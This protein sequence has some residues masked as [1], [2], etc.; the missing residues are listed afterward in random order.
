MSSNFQTIKDIRDFFKKELNDLYPEK[1]ISGIT[2]LILK[3]QFGIDRLH[4]FSDPAR[5][6]PA[7]M[8]A[9]IT[10]IC[11]EL[12][13]GRPIQYIIG[14]TLFFDCIIRVNYNTLIPRPETEEL[15]DLIIRENKEFNGKIIDFGTG[16]GCIAIA[17][18]KNLP[19]SKITG[20]DI[21][22]PALDLARSNALKNN[23]YIEFCKGDILH[24]DFRLCPETDI[25]VSNPPYVLESEKQFME[26]NIIDFEP[27]KALFVPD[28]DSLR[29]YKAIVEISGQILSPGGR[30]YFE[31]NEKKASE[32][33]GLLEKAG[34]NDIQIINDLNGKNRF[35][36][37]I[38]NG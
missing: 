13:T 5:T 1:E 33:S 26:K 10:E 35:V 36:K 15:V 20:I 4:Q 8:I 18:Q 19:F 27:H 2:N 22:K 3:T 23:V 29:F 25:I 32:I 24:F 17:L 14:E 34:Y 12:K 38:L 7:S 21:S 6:I 30:I 16:S 9:G 11:S 37:G 28:D 31:I